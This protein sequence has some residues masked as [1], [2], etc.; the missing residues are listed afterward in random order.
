MLC[1][2]VRVLQLRSTQ[3]VITVS[4]SV[5]SVVTKSESAHCKFNF[6]AREMANQQESNRGSHVV[7][8]KRSKR[9]LEAVL[10]SVEF[11]SGLLGKLMP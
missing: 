3:S 7:G 9:I 5:S 4:E 1:T 10:S 11:S 8:V 2:D 6:A